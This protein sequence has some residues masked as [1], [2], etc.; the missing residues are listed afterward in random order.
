MELLPHLLPP[1]LPRLDL[2]AI[3]EIL[4]VAVLIYG[5]LL[6]IKDTTAVMLVRGLAVL[7]LGGAAVSSFFQLPV[8]GWLI[9]TALPAL[10]VAIPILFQPELRRAL[11]HLGHL[12]GILPSHVPVGS[13]AHRIEVLVTAARRLAERRW[14]ALLVL[15][16]ETSLG[17]YA[18]TG[19][20]LDAILSVA[21][22]EQIF[23]PNTRLHDG[24]A[25]VRDDRILAAACLLPLAESIE[26]DPELGTRHRA[27]LGISEQ[28]D[29]VVIILSEETGQ[30]SCAE[31]GHL[32][33]DLDDQQLRALLAR[34][35]G[36]TRGDDISRLLHPI[37]RRDR[38]PA[39]APGQVQLA[40]ERGSLAARLGGWIFR[41]SSRIS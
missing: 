31:H 41:G 28:T 29:A 27:A 39:P 11:E 25:I 1:D 21:I 38:D 32:L 20:T 16:R 23:H 5:L 15:E 35:Y 8:L 33:R 4:I 40:S 34:V 24:A 22:I 19:E 17:E 3:A 10:L 13:Q 37:T 6:F 30:I 9:R 14:G 12:Q 36:P 7:V 18:A 26:L 2:R